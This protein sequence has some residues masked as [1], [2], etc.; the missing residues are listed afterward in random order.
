MLRSADLA[1]STLQGL[2]ESEVN[3]TVSAFWGC[4]FRWKLGDGLNG[5]VAEGSAAT[6]DQAV[7]NLAQAAIEHFPESAFARGLRF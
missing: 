1:T 4:G 5:F 2:Y 3:Y 6:F 7:S